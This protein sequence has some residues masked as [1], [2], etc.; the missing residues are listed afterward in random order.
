MPEADHPLERLWASRQRPLGA[1]GD[2]HDVVVS[3]VFVR[4]LKPAPVEGLLDDVLD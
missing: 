4:D 3:E 1:A 2:V